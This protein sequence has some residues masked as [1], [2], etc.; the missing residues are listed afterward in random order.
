MSTVCLKRSVA[1]L[2]AL[3]MLLGMMPVAAFATEEALSDDNRTIISILGDS[4]STF[5]GYLPGGNAT[6]YPTSYLNRVEDTWW[7]QLITEL[8]AKLGV[9]ESWSGSCVSVTSGERLPMASLE[10]IQNLDNNGTPNVILFFGGTNDIAFFSESTPVGSFDTA[11]APVQADLTET[12]WETFAD[13]YVAAI[14]RMRYYYPEARIISILPTVNTKYY[15]DATLEKYN[16]VMRAI[17]KHYGVEYVDLVAEGY[18]TKL[19][20]DATHPNTAGM[21]FI[22]AAVKE[23]LQPAHSHSY[24]GVVTAPTCNTQGYTT[25]TCDCGESYVSDYVDATGEHAYEN[26]ICIGCG[27]ENPKLENYQSKVISVLG[28]SISTFAGYIPTADGFNMEHLARYPQDDLLTDVNETWWMQ[29]I[30]QLDAKLGINDSWRGATVSGAAPVTTGTTGEN[31]AMHNLTRVQNLGSNGTP[32]VIL[33]YGGTNDLAHVS[34]IGTFDAASAPTEADLTTRKWDNLADGYVHTLLRLKHFYPD[35]QIVCLL[36][37]YT[38]T[39]YTNEKLAKGNEVM[40][41]ICEHYG[42]PYVDLRE[43]G[44]TTAE[45]PDGI[46]PDAVGMDY[47]TDAVVDLLLDEC[48]IPSG[49]HVVHSVT[50][51]LTEAESSKAYYKGVSHGKSFTATIS[52]E[53]VAVTVM[54]GGEDIT[55]SCY[56][57]GVIHVPAVTGDLVITATGEKKA[58]HADYLLQLPEDVCGKTNLWTILEHNKEYY[59]VDG[60]GVHASGKVYSVTIPVEPGDQLWATSFQSSGANGGTID[61]IRLT[62]F[63]ETEVIESVSADKVYEE[64]VNQGYLTAPE[65]AVAVNVVMWDNS[66]SNELYILNREHVYENGTCTGCGEPQPGPIVITKQPVPADA[67]VG[68]KAVLT[69]EAQ[70]EGLKYQ[71]YFRNTPT[72]ALSRSSITGNVYG[73]TVT[74]DNANRVLYC[75]ITDAHGNKVTTETVNLIE[76]KELSVAK[77]PADASAVLGEKA[78]VTVEAAGNPVTYTWYFRDAGDKNF[79]RSTLTGPS[80]SLTMTEDRAGREVY[81]VITDAH[82]SKV[83][84]ET[85]TLKLA[86]KEELKIL[87][88]PVPDDAIVGEKATISVVAQ[89]DALKYTWYF[90]DA[91]KTTFTKSTITSSIYSLTVKDSNANRVLYCVITDAHGNQLTTDTVKLIQGGT[92]TITKQPVPAEAAIGETA[93]VVVEVQGEGLKYQWYFKDS[94]EGV[95]NKS[96]ITGNVYSITVKNTNVNRELYCIITDAYGNQVKT[97][98]VKLVQGPKTELKI[99]TQPV[100][101][102][103]VIGE[104]ATVFVEA[105]GEGLSYQWYF[106]N[107]PNGALS[108]SS[109]TGSSYKVTVT[110]SNAQRVLY[111]VITDAYG[112]KVTTDTVSL[113]RNGEE[114]PATYYG[115]LADALSGTAGSQDPTGAVAKVLEESDETVV[116]LLQDVQLAET[117]TI[118]RAITL[119][120]NGFTI[121]STAAPAVSVDAENAMI[122]GGEVSLTASGKGTSKAPAVAVL[123]ESGTILEIRDAKVTAVDEKNGTVVGVLGQAT[124][125]L[126]LS[127]TTVLVTAETSLENI[128]VHAKGTAVL[129]DCTV[130]AESDYT[131]NKAGTAYAALSRGIRAEKSLELYNCYV[132][133]SHAGVLAMSTVYVDG[134]TYEGYGH[135]SFYFGGSNTTSYIYNASVNWAEMREGT[136][137]DSVAGT[138]GAGLYVGNGAQN[139]NI[140]M[141]NCQVYGTLYGIV[142]RN[143]GG[144]KNNSIYISNSTF[145]G[146]SK[147]AYRNGQSASYETLKIYNGVGNDYSAIKGTLSVNP[148]RVIDTNESYAPNSNT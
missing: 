98:V 39:Y 95:L 90:K 8:D 17:C 144:E 133:G 16:S 123:A 11:T 10:R 29:I 97:D 126:K 18:T 36:P 75:V 57:D 25:Y 136:Y 116:V 60:W 70:G 94:P 85:A 34:K 41:A 88:Q 12:E 2:L 45:L 147:Y 128:G 118:A 103:A 109:I 89:G 93:T 105:Q 124:T 82:G 61:G 20:G 125:E 140:Y 55:S 115:S 132:W 54:M 77:Q 37:T 142:L 62:W 91:G 46:H 28:D 24:S 87:T 83:T 145:T 19:L 9:N 120:L 122:C 92:L 148:K 59:T 141:D 38:A 104:T 7:M 65:G 56:T 32:D 26:G 50:H 63:D 58:V 40:G 13:G 42:V 117:L 134:G 51:K 44:I 35:A 30:A 52:G 81:C 135:G 139:V 49:E 101:A 80:Y 100:P 127:N 4:I 111:C 78:T 67:L 73:I 138:N 1:F 71:W 79:Q 68:E 21:D 53:N 114:D 74:K 48:E 76:I 143:S 14:L 5:E 106:R 47:I 102:K 6:Y 23:K 99:L 130:I 112:N 69:V 43:C 15:N 31:A 121:A 22:S 84:T 119:D 96:S 27:L 33:F 129:R 131:A 146:C 64:F 108:K 113:I 137:A 110:K 107:T 66:I 86:V 72:G 3:V